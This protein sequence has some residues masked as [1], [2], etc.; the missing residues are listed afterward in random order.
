MIRK[1]PRSTESE[2]RRA[3]CE[4]SLDVRNTG[5]PAEPFAVKATLASKAPSST[6]TAGPATSDGMLARGWPG[7]P[8]AFSRSI[9]PGHDGHT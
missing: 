3:G 9:A 4:G 8:W 6:T 5:S 1:E 7:W 2:R